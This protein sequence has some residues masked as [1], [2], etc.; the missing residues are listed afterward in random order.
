MARR[1]VREHPAQPPRVVGRQAERYRKAVGRGQAEQQRLLIRGGLHVPVAHRVDV[2]QRRVAGA[3]PQR[4]LDQLRQRHQQHA[5]RLMREGKNNRRAAFILEAQLD[6]PAAWSH[7]D[8]GEVRANDRPPA[9]HWKV[10]GLVPHSDRT[11]PSRL[12]SRS[13]APVRLDCTAPAAIRTDACP[14][15]ARQTAGSA[16][17]AALAPAALLGSR[18]CS[19]CGSRSHAHRSLACSVPGSS[20]GS[21]E[22]LLT[23]IVKN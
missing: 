8:V 15:A 23:V 1:E 7:P 13:A 19:L 4:H 18:W 12:A 17:R 20:R 21:T 11:R 2:P 16:A 9:A 5:Q 10:H 3:L 6:D 14:L 22:Q